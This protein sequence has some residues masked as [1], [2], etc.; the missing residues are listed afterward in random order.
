[1]NVKTILVARTPPSAP[2]ERMKERIVEMIAEM[3]A[4]M[5]TANVEC[6]D[7][8]TRRKRRSTMAFIIGLLIRIISSEEI[9]IDN[10]PQNQRE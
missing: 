8:S 2:Q 1:M 5:K 9:Y 7:L 6:F 10:V 4:E 3:I